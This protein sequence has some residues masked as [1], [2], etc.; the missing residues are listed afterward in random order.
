LLA[1]RGTHKHPLGFHYK[2]W[3]FVQNVSLAACLLPEVLQ[4]FGRLAKEVN[5]PDGLGVLAFN[6]E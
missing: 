5:E 3:V 2:E 1:I 6:C 4:Q